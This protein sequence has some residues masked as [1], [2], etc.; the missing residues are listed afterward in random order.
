MLTTSYLS[1]DDPPSKREILRT[2]LRLFAERGID[3]VTVRAIAEEAGYTNP[4]LFKF[5]ATK[6]ALALY[7]FERCY[8]QLYD[9]LRDEMAD[10]G[11]TRERIR[12]IAS[13]SIE[14]IACDPDA[15]LFVQDTL[16]VMWPRVSAATRR[17]S[18]FSLIRRT[19]EEGMD[20]G[21]VRQT[22]PDLLVTA[23]TGTLQQ[24]ARMLHFGQ[25]KGPARQWLPAL[26]DLIGRVVAP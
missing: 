19:L 13:A 25:L 17:K 24:F 3:A 26:Q 14:Q 20:E 11:T 7:L 1:T 9:R 4:A 21:V 22:S 2:A 6:D 8:E 18:I 16:R 10:A 15:F 23:I 5:F 12:A